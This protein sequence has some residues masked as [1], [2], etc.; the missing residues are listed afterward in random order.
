MFVDKKKISFLFQVYKE[1]FKRY[2]KIKQ[3]IFRN[4]DDEYDLPITYLLLHE[5]S[6]NTYRTA[7]SECHQ[8]IS[9]ILGEYSFENI[10]MDESIKQI[11]S[12]LENYKFEVTAEKSVE[13]IDFMLEHFKFI[14]KYSISLH[15]YYGDYFI[16]DMIHPIIEAICHEINLFI[17]DDKTIHE[18]K[19]TIINIIQD[20]TDDKIDSFECK[21]IINKKRNEL[22]T[23]FEKD[24][25]HNHNKEKVI[26]CISLLKSVIEEKNTLLNHFGTDNFNRFF[27]T[28][29]LVIL[30]E[31]KNSSDIIAYD[32]YNNDLH[33]IFNNYSEGFLTLEQTLQSLEKLVFVYHED[34]STPKEKN[35]LKEH[36]IYLLSLVKFIRESDNDS[37][38]LN[39]NDSIKSITVKINKLIFDEIKNIVNTDNLSN[40]LVN[41]ILNTIDSYIFQ[42]VSVEKCFFDIKCLI[43][44]RS[45]IFG[46]IYSF[47]LNNGQ[48]SLLK[49]SNIDEEGVHICLFDDFFNYRP[50]PNDSIDFND[51]ETLLSH[52]PVNHETFVDFGC[53]KFSLH[54]VSPKEVEDYYF[55]KENFGDYI[56]KREFYKLIN[57]IKG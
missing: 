42:D 13:P 50:N 10:S 25:Q 14:N 1:W 28:I 30:D 23:K 37:T 38:S 56:S 36:I 55:W 24:V 21:K 33:T 29:E 26:K 46:G 12:I 32:D 22:K 15:K 39:E 41:S 20:F 57:D 3:N 5:L 27:T 40:E 49:V 11:Q 53:K 52:V 9:K 48:Y 18:N 31:M 35:K 6:G 54:P 2:F 43:F 47:E 17:Y 51:S 4:S 34:E 8:K 16:S 19:N 45:Y 44:D 7:P